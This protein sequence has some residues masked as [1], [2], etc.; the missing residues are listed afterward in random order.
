MQQQVPDKLLLEARQPAVLVAPVKAARIAH[1][2][3]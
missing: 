3:R 2:W 1:G